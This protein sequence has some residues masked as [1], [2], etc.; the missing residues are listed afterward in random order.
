MLNNTETKKLEEKN[1]TPFP[2]T[3]EERKEIVF[4]GKNPPEL[5]HEGTPE[6]MEKA[7]VEAKKRFEALTKSDTQEKDISDEEKKRREDIKS[8][9]GSEN[10]DTVKASSVLFLQEKG[11]DIASHFL[12]NKANPSLSVVAGTMVEGA[13]FEVNF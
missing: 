11:V 13:D 3:Q 1:N 9:I 6:E 8:I 4:D 5:G 10:F 2:L 7:R 12:I